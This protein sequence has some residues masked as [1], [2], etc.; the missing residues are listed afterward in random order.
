[1]QVIVSERDI[2]NRYAQTQLMLGTLED[3]GADMSKID[4][5][6]MSGFSHCQYINVQD[7]E[8][9]FIFAEMI[10]EFIQKQ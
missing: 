3:M 7:E 2:A 8:G 1:M 6:F 5:R 10:R 9:K 4:Y